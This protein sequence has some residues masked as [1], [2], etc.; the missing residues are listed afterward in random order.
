MTERKREL[1]DDRAKGLITAMVVLLSVA[2][3][4][5]A[6]LVSYPETLK[7]ILRPMIWLHDASG[8]LAVLLSGVYLN[9]HLRRVWRMK[10]QKTNRYSGL[11]L[12]G[13]WGLCALTG[14]YGH[15]F[16][17]KDSLILY[18]IHYITAVATIVVVC[19]HGAWAYRPRR[20]ARDR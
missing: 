2:A 16:E 15:V 4:T 10:K 9:I 6:A 11:L 12:V 5:A 8:D 7:L 18:R 20:I 19:F 14:A 17:L 13:I 3:S 1:K